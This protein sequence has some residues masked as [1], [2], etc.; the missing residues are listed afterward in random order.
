MRPG[1][2][3]TESGGHGGIIKAQTLVT[4]PGADATSTLRPVVDV[5]AETQTQTVERLKMAHIR[6]MQGMSN[7]TC[8]AACSDSSTECSD[9]G[10]VSDDELD[11]VEWD[12]VAFKM[13]RVF[14]QFA[15]DACDEEV[16]RVSEL[17]SKER[18][19][20]RSSA[21]DILESYGVFGA[22]VGTWTSRC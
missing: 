6:S 9:D 19:T 14:E 16:D 4:L 12:D 13:G 5:V 15:E 18:V 1:H 3:Y 2:A 21:W 8:G 17:A 10:N 7:R 20:S 11:S 22:P